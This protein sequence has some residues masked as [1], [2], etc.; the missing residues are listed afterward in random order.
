MKENSICGASWKRFLSKIEI[1]IIFP[2]VAAERIG[3]KYRVFSNSC[4]FVI[5]VFLKND[6][7]P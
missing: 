1:E 7:A 5:E 6:K 3:R 4:D 2:S